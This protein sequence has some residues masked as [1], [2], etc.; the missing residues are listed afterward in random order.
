MTTSQRIFNVLF[1]RNEQL[2]APAFISLLNFIATM[3]QKVR[4]QILVILLWALLIGFSIHSFPL[5]KEGFEQSRV[6]R[7]GQ[8]VQKYFDAEDAYFRVMNYR[9]H[10]VITDGGTDNGN[11]S[12]PVNNGS[13]L[14]Y[15]NASDKG[16]GQ[17]QKL[18][19]DLRELPLMTKDLALSENWLQ[20]YLQYYRKSY[21]REYNTTENFV[22]DLR[23]F[24]R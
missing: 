18:L 2:A 23:K 11:I 5:L 12:V 22:P 7:K 24:L 6:C 1:A 9:I 15:A 16:Q 4:V 20:A 13:S 21:G 10:V 8:E 3:F 14:N 17:I 19:S